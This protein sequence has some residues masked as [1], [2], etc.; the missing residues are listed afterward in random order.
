MK[1]AIQQA[2]AVGALIL[3]ALS[4]CDNVSWGGAD[5]VIVPPPPQTRSPSSPAVEEGEPVVERLPEGAILYYAVRTP[6]GGAM[7]PVG[8]IDGDSLRAIRAAGDPEAFAARFIAELM[9]QGSE[10][11]LFHEGA[12]VGTLVVESAE[13]LAGGG[14]CALPRATGSLELST[15]ASAAS[16]FLALSRLNAPEAVRRSG[17]ALVPSR[18]MQVIAPIIA[19][20][21]MRRRGA[22]LPGNWQR[23][24]AQLQPFPVFTAQQPGY[25][26]T[27][28]VG[29]TLG[30]GLDDDGYSIFYVG[31]P[32]ETSYDTAYVDYRPYPQTGKAAPRVIDFLDWDRD[33]RV[34]LLLR[35]YGVSESWFEAV[36]PD[37]DGEW[38]RIFQDDCKGSASPVLVAPARSDTPG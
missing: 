27:F 2:R 31:I 14:A 20:R 12:R 7:V 35:V 32:H 22:S 18:G 33:D 4:G 16:E 17:P 19:E 9:R 3:I 11:V 37:E 13:T 21:L 30:P 15:T 36:G 1:R 34:E 8:E 25:A 28:L 26:T 10:F 23:A 24:M 29:D 6:T 38:S 5:V